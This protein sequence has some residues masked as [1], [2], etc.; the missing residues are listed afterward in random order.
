M[1]TV[2]TG[3]GVGGRG[4][5]GSV[6]NLFP[7]QS[8][9]TSQN[10]LLLRKKIWSRCKNDLTSIV[11]LKL[12]QFLN[13]SRMKI[14]EKS[15]FWFIDKG[16]VKT[17]KLFHNLAPFRPFL[18]KSFPTSATYFFTQPL[19]NYA[20]EHSTAW[21]WQHR[22]GGGGVAGARHSNCRKKSLMV[23]DQLFMYIVVYVYN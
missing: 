11:L 13:H 18:V 20:A 15:N 16:K 9:Q 5:G 8:G 3:G 2:Q 7:R 10:I 23:K 14:C 6:A 21:H 1:Y 4:V 22:W 19:L 17:T 12:D